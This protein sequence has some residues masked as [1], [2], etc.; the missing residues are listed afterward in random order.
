M[1][2]TAAAVSSTERRVTS[3]TGQPWRSNSRR[4]SMISSRTASVST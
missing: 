3:I 1:L 4:A 2:I